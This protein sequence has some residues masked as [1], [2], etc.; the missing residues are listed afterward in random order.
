MNTEKMISELQRVAAAH[1]NDKLFTGDLNITLMC[2]DMIDKIKELQEEIN[3]SYCR[4]WNDA[5]TRNC[6]NVQSDLNEDKKRF[7]HQEQSNE[8]YWV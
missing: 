8:D 6:T 3:K 5:M 4:G 1:Q 2:N 7:V